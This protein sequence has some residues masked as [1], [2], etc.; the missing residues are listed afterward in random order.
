MDKL[1][2]YIKEKTIENNNLNNSNDNGK[3]NIST[4]D[5]LKYYFSRHKILNNN[6]N[7]NCIFCNEYHDFS[8]IYKICK[9]PEILIMCFNY[10]NDSSLDIWCNTRID[11]D[12]IINLDNDKYILKGVISRNDENNVYNTYCRDDSNKSWAFYDIKK[13]NNYDLFKNKDH[14]F[15]IVL[16]YQKLINN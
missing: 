8:I 2:E 1:R 7:I 9:Y 12:D 14:V 13:I 6:T 5:C 11:F 3:I 16:F 4:L 15:P 10:D